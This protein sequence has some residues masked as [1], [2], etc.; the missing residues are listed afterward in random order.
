M[1]KKPSGQKTGAKSAATLTGVAR[2]LN[3]A[4][5]GG[6]RLPPLLFLTDETRVPDPRPALDRLPADCA[7]VFRHYGATNRE[8]LA[9]ELARACKKQGRVFLVAGD[10]ELARAVKA[11]G[12][13]LPEAMLNERNDWRAIWPS[14]LLTAAAHSSLTLHEACVA[15]CDAALLSPVFATVSHPDKGALGE[16]MFR[17]LTKN[18]ALPVYALG[19]ITNETAPR[20][21]ASGAVGLAAIGGLLA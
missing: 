3:A 11:D 18:A 8:R 19:G 12:L 20:L 9:A 1:D 13:H 14:G 10:V 5:D 7:V 2:A 16:D 17:L 6:E 4:H 15:G 21:I